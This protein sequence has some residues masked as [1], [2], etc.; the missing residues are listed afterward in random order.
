ME[1]PVSE[2]SVPPRNPPQPPPPNRRSTR[3]AR[4]P[5]RADCAPAHRR[6]SHSTSPWRTHRSSACPAAPHRPP[7]AASPRSHR[8]AA[9][10][11]AESSSR[12][13]RASP[14]ITS[15]SLIPTGTPANGGSSS[16]FAAIAS[17]FAACAI[18]RCGSAPESCGCSCRPARPRPRSARSA[19]RPPPSLSP[20]RWQ[21][22]SR[23][24]SIVIAVT[25]NRLRS[26]LHR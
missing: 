20:L 6:S 25:Q 17:I 1:P 9:C 18:A 22:P 13:S 12:R 7:P 16:P 19:A 26:S 5:A 24:P 21:S 15:T 4:G 23:T 8:K 11:L 2:P 3:P 14:C 10:S